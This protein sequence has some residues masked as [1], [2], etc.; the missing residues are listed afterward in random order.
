MSTATATDDANENFTY[1][2]LGRMLTA[3]KTVDSNSVSVSEI[4]Y[5]DIGKIGY[6]P[7][8]RTGHVPLDL[9]FTSLV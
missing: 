3:P 4:A 7:I 1:D 8:F 2:G 5:N 6:S 9:L